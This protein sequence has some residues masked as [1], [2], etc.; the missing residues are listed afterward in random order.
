MSHQEPWNDRFGFWFNVLLKAFSS[1]FWFQMLNKS[2]KKLVSFRK[3]IVSAYGYL[4]IYLTRVRGDT[5][6]RPQN[7]CSSN[8]AS[9]CKKKKKKKKKKWQV[10]YVQS[11]TEGCSQDFTSIFASFNHG[12]YT[13]GVC[14]V[15]RRHTTTKFQII[16]LGTKL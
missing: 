15:T 3:K 5:Q 1:P 14:D 16:K 12:Q 8:N 2:S 13:I 11:D 10:I 4:V 9:G 6:A 7:T